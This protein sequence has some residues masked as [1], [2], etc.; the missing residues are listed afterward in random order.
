LV[1][2]TGTTEYHI[3]DYAIT[4]ENRSPHVEAQA[5]VQLFNNIAEAALESAVAGEIVSYARC[6]Q[7]CRGGGL[8]TAAAKQQDARREG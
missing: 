2:T 4:I 5:T 7:C 8:V 1:T 6:F 3:H